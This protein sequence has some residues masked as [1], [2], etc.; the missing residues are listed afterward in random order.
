VTVT[1]P[2]HSPIS[3]VP[4]LARVDAL[5]SN[6]AHSVE[7]SV[8]LPCLNEEATVAGCVASIREV[9]DALAKPYEVIVVDNASSDRSA[10]IAGDAGARV[11]H[12]SIPGY[13]SACRA[14]LAAAHGRHLVLGDADGT[15]DFSVVPQL[16]S[17]LDGDADMV[18]GNR[19]AGQI[20][21]GA[22]PWAHRRLGTPLL[23][24]MVNLLFG[25]AIGDVNC[26]IRA[27]TRSAYSRLDV[28]ST[29]MEFASEMVVRA[30]QN[31]LTLAETP[32]DYR[33]RRSGEAKLRTWSDGWR[34]LR[35]VLG[36][37]MTSGRRSRKAILIDLTAR[38]DMAI[39]PR[40]AEQ[41]DA[42]RLRI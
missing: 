35:L 32:V 31:G 16:I 39:D 38:P 19:L 26:G 1:T 13:G 15:Y 11:V 28:D 37:W 22:M 33:R 21:Q 3:L 18:L 23:T 42:N 20:E 30:A 34:H 17:L 7:V 9:M 12:E 5:A 40:E 6:E 10:A 41:P 8:V 24:G 4:E 2:T 14:G 36:S 25:V 29:G 27:I